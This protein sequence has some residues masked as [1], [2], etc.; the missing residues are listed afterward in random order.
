VL[1]LIGYVFLAMPW[2]L[3]VGVPLAA[4]VALLVG[5]RTAVYWVGAYFAL[6][7]Y[8][9]NNSFGLLDPLQDKNFYSRGTGTFYFS[10]INVMLFGL[11]LQAFVARRMALPLPVAHNLR[12][13]AFTFLAVFAGNILVAQFLPHVHWTRVIGPAGLFNVFNFM[14]AFYALTSAM[15]E[16]RDFDRL[17]K[18]ILFCAVT[19]GLW[20]LVRFAVLGGDPANFY[21]NTQQ[22]DVRL[23]FFDINDNMVA[24]LA[25]FLAAWRLLSGQCA[26][27]GSR[28]LHLGIVAL[29][30][31]IIVFSYRRTAWGG[32]LLVLVLLAFCRPARQRWWLLAVSFSAAIPLLAYKLAQRAGTKAQGG[33]W[34]ETALPD[35]MRNGQ[36]SFTTGRFAELYA[37]WLSIKESPLWGLGTWGSYDGSRFSELAWHRGD[38]GWMHSGV[39]HIMLKS[40]LIG[41]AGMV[42]AIALLL[43]FLLRE[44][45]T[46]DEQQRGLFFLGVAGLLFMLPNWLIGTPLIEFRTMQMMAL[47]T[48]LPYLA[49][50]AARGAATAAASVRPVPWVF[51]IRPLRVQPA[52]L[53]PHQRL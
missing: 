52:L 23:T 18:L 26:G 45:H 41:V 29:E 36:I 34:L 6:L 13:P 24:A 43:R 19:R 1:E 10:A 20:G 25:L 49:V 50:V 17:I 5:R 3:A 31:F 28:L 22:L 12:A 30:L 51:G 53:Q 11:A 8:L 21:A 32:L 15:R 2:V 9:P 46:L 7:L 40:G 35:V 48:A 47:C 44:R 38:F 27:L 16:P 42:L 33:S 39:L 14:L 4:M 37:A